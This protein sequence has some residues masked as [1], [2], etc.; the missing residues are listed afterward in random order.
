MTNYED[1]GVYV[2]LP[3]RLQGA[4]NLT[5]VLPKNLSGAIVLLW[6]GDSS[7]K[8]RDLKAMIIRL[9]E[10]KPLAI[11]VAG[12]RTNESFEVLLETLSVIETPDHIMT[13]VIHHDDSISDF[14]VATFPDQLRFDDWQEYFV[15]AVGNQD[16]QQQIRDLLNKAVK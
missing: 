16:L 6:L 1:V 2:G 4:N 7:W 8:T 5:E 15:I 9:A 10:K 3:V 14:F 13:G 12:E 11:V